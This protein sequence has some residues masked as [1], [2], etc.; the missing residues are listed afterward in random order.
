MGFL[1]M[2]ENLDTWEAKK[3][4]AGGY[5]KFFKEWWERDTRD[6]VMRDRNHPSIVI[7]SVGNE[8]MMA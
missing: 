8:F 4:H 1:V 7:Y 2:D 6:M 3:Q 5:D